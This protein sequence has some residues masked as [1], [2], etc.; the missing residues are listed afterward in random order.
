MRLITLFFLWVFCFEIFLFG[1]ESSE[2]SLIILP[3]QVFQGDYYAV[4][5]LIE[6]SGVIKGNAYLAGT[7]VSIDGVIEGSLFILAG[8]YA[9]TGKVHGDIWALSGG[10][11][12]S[13]EAFKDVVLVAA[14]SQF[15]DKGRVV[16][17]VTVF[18][19]STEMEGWV[20]GTV[21]ALASHLK[22][23]G[24]IE[25][26]LRSFAGKLRIFSTADIKGDLKYKSNEDA[27]IDPRA[28]IGGSILYQHTI[29]HDLMQKPLIRGLVIGSKVVT[30]LMNF[31]YAFIIG[32][33]IIRLFPKKLTIALNSLKQSP[34]RAFWYG[35]VLLVLFPLASLLLLA[36]V[37][38]APFA[39]TLI[40]L[41]IVTFYTAKIFTILWLANS[42]FSKLKWK[43]NGI[44][45]LFLGQI[46]Y[47]IV[48]AIP[49][50]G[51]FFSF[52]AM[53]MGLGAI[54]A[55]QKGQN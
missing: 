37:I 49:F 10:A 30:F 32:I 7:Q 54:A 41:N 20:G 38:G 3:G 44:F 42:L 53:V 55:F 9:L 51:I 5:D 11:V 1:D 4:G 26:N 23:S 34:L 33:V 14:N 27:Y 52:F 19:G 24:V 12:M 15:T 16:G 47:S 21:T 45:T 40:A 31:I 36:T 13:G 18:A 2:E 50:I 25:K 6:I 8:N 28:Q 43:K 46:M 17:D 29:L 22:V 48:V 35:S 39:L